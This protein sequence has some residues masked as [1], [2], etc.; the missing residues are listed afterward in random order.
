V[1]LILVYYRYLSFGS[2]IKNCNHKDLVIYLIILVPFDG[3]S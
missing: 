1:P 2:L 3:I